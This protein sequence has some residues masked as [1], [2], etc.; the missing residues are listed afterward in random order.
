MNN[1][2]KLRYKHLGT[3]IDVSCR[4]KKAMAVIMGDHNFFW[5]VTLADAEKLHKAGYEYA[6]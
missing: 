1:I 6:Y 5:V 3:A 4:A 2:F